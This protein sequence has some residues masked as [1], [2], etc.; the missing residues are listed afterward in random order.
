MNG[1]TDSTIVLQWLQG[2][3]SYKQ[4]VHKRVKYINVKTPITWRYVDTI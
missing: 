1:Q 2:N 4:F 3:G